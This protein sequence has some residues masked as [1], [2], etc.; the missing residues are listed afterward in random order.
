M[1]PSVT[2]HRHRNNPTLRSRNQGEGIY[3]R[4]LTAYALISVLWRSSARQQFYQVR[5]IRGVY[6]KDNMTVAFLLGGTAH[7]LQDGMLKFLGV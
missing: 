2:C 1:H 4:R 6:Y 5:S 3:T 7:L